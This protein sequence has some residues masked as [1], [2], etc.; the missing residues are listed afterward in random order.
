MKMQEAH[1]IGVIVFS[2]KNI[3]NTYGVHH[4]RENK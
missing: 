3:L 1:D 4:S 2:D